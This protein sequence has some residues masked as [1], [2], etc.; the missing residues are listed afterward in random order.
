MGD[1]GLGGLLMRSVDLLVA[2][3]HATVQ[4]EVS[5]HGGYVAEECDADYGWVFLVGRAGDFDPVG[6]LA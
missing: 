4:Q 2:V 3:Q 1:R 5:Y 6:Y